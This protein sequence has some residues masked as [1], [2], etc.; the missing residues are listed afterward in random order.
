MQGV[1]ERWSVV[2]VAAWNV[3]NIHPV[4]E[5]AM[6]VPPTPARLLLRRFRAARSKRAAQK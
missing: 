4:K 2:S 1:S 6:I 3:L 5:V